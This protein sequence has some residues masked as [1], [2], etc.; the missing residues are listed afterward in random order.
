MKTKQAN[1]IAKFTTETNG[2]NQPNKPLLSA[3]KVICKKTE[4]VVVDCRTYMSASRN[5][6]K[7]DACIWVSIADAKKPKGFEYGHVSGHG[8]ASGWGY[9]KESSAIGAAILDAGIELYGTPY[10]V[11]SGDKVDLK[12]RCHIGG[13]GGEASEQACLAIAYAAGYRDCIVVQIG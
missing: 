7:V 10:H 2:A 13:V 8:N 11:G 3:I 5:A 6:S 1:M 9:D 12:R 4:R